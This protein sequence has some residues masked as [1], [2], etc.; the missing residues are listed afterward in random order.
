MTA[1]FGLVLA[2]GRS[3]R[4]QRDKAALHYGGRPQLE[5]AYGLALAHTAG[6]Y[7]SVRPDQATEPLRAALPCIVDDGSV[8]GPIAGI[9]AAQAARADVA[10]LVLACDLPFLDAAT[11]ANLLSRRNRACLA[12]AYRSAHDGLPE[13][14]CAVYEPASRKPILQYVAAG[15]SCP[16]RFL[17]GAAV[18]LLE[19]PDRR[20]LDNV[21]TPRE[22]AAARRTLAARTG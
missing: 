22:F 19:L 18:E 16:R 17:G 7:V 13:P 2:G 8:E 9:I 4:M 15:G 5:L 12:T 10:W 3:T 20:A 21:N 1:V 14:L 11:L 6:A